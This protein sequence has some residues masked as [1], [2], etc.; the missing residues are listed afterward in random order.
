MLLRN[1]KLEIFIEIKISIPTK[2]NCISVNWVI[3]QVI[4]GK[5]WNKWKIGNIK[6]INVVKYKSCFQVKLEKVW[7][8]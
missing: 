1:L 3:L 6:S 5:S 7:N 8:R 4:I 2:K